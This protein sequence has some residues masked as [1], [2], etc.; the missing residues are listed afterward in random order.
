MK[1]LLESP[2]R[3]GADCQGNVPYGE[4]IGTFNPA[5]WTPARRA[6]LEMS[7][8]LMANDLLSHACVLKPPWKTLTLGVSE[9]FQIAEHMDVLGRR[10]TQRDTDAL[11]HF[12][13]PFPMHLFQLAVPELYPF[14]INWYLVSKLISWV[15][16]AIHATQYWVQPLLNPI[17]ESWETLIY[18]LL[19]RR[20]GSL[21]LWLASEAGGYLSDWVLNV[22][23]CSHS[24]YLTS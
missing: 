1:W 3:W 18:G 15:L 22:G 20:P 8:S 2:L 23:V 24:E 13:I 16:W 6:E 17:C 5:L 21:D 12:C 9:G 19:V 14:V 11:Y 4:R 10:Y 7:Q